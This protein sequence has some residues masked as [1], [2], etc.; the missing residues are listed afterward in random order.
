MTVDVSHLSSEKRDFLKCNSELLSS[1]E[2]AI[3]N[4][5]RNVQTR[6]KKLS[7]G[8]SKLQRDLEDVDRRVEEA[9]RR[10][11]ELRREYMVDPHLREINEKYQKLIV[12]SESGSSL[13]CPK[14]KEGD[15]GNKM[16]K[17][18]W[19]MKCNTALIS[20]NMLEKWR[21]L[22]EIKISRDAIKNELHRLNPG[23]NPD[24]KE[25]AT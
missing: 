2:K 21:N 19:C 22:P 5:V 6:E 18:S 12:K 25:E 15:H 17:Q 3:P 4:Q 16:N 24:N 11:D 7:K 13:V 20:K 10:A 9:K 1:L 14:C 8:K 23:L